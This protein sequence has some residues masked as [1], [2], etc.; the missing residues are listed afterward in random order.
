MS[1]GVVPMF[2]ITGMIYG[3][4]APIYIGSATVVMLPRW[5]R[6]LAGR[7][8]SRH[9]VTHWTCIPTMI[10]DLF[11]SPNYKSFDL[12]SLRY[13]SGGGAAMPHAVA[14]RLQQRVRPHLRRRLRPDRDR[15]RR[16][17]PTRPSAPS[18]NAW[19]SRSSASTRASSTPRR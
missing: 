10:I 18:C 8:I 3:V 12:T 17:T 7:L 15:R 4:L 9:R 13:L 2:H 1:L 14:E 5:D 19:A 16:A 11:G 6:E